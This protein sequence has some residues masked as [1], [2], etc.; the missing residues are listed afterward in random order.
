MTSVYAVGIPLFVYTMHA[1]GEEQPSTSEATIMCWDD[2]LWQ[3]LREDD[4]GQDEDS[5]LL[6][7]DSTRAALWGCNA[8]T[9][10]AAA[11][12]SASSE[13]FRYFSENHRNRCLQAIECARAKQ[14]M[15]T[16]SCI[17]V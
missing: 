5:E 9:T 3:Q 1:I 12:L 13:C 7:I 4:P 6:L 2:R 17:C 10:T 15:Y 14:G 16:L 11:R 8:V